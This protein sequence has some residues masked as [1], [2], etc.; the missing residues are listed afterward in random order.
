VS[1]ENIAF[2][3]KRFGS[4]SDERLVIQVGDAGVDGEIIETTLNLG[5]RL[6]Y[7]LEVSPR[8]LPRFEIHLFGYR[9]GLATPG[10]VPRAGL[11]PQ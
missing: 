1:D 10:S 4:N 7:D 11:K 9:H 2:A 6:G 3:V 5:G 8:P